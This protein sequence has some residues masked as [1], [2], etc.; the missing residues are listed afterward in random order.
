MPPHCSF[1]LVKSC[2]TKSGEELAGSLDEL[3]SS[4]DIL[5]IQMVLSERTRHIIGKEELS[6]MKSSAI[7][8]NTSR[9]GL[10]DTGALV[11]AL[12]KKTISVSS[13]FC[14]AISPPL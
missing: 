1:R 2:L 7:L 14:L 6:K 13:I 4:A 5:S 3:L 10:V 9:G 8:I 11:D 12:R